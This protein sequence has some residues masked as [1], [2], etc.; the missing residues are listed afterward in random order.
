ME[1]IG[2]ASA[3]PAA[4]EPYAVDAQAI[5]LGGAFIR[6]IMSQARVGVAVLDRDGRFILINEHM[7]ELDGVSSGRHIEQQLIQIA[8][9]FNHDDEAPFLQAL[10]GAYVARDTLRATPSGDRSCMEEWF[11]LAGATGSI[12]G[13]IVNIRDVT[14]RDLAYSRL[15]SVFASAPV[16]IA[17]FDRN[18]RIVSINRHMAEWSALDEA[19]VTGVSA[20]DLARDSWRSM[21]PHFAAALRGEATSVEIDRRAAGAAYGPPHVTA[22]YVP[23]W[24]K[25]VVAGVTITATDISAQVERERAEEAAARF[26]EDVIHMASH[27]LRTPLTSLIAFTERLVRV[28]GS[29]PTMTLDSVQDDL[30]I[31]HGESERMARTLDRILDMVVL[32]SG[33]VQLEREPVALVPI[34]RRQLH[35]LRERY[36]HVVLDERTLGQP[37]V[38]SDGDRIAQ[39]ITNLLENAAR[40][41]GDSAHVVVGVREESDAPFALIEVQDD[42]PGIQEHELD[43]IFERHYRGHTT[44]GATGLGLG[45]YLSRVIATGLGGSLTVSTDQERGVTFALRL[46]LVEE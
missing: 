34:I 28:A 9:F 1:E 42:G 15:Q 39:V 33:S 43:S 7:A 16:G 5:E 29:S 23:V 10:T 12:I 13:V 11:P 41:A 27:E 4:R 45:L 8:P 35:M 40:Y 44:N 6:A 30:V 18:L 17:T 14:E 2:T 25:G 20:Q 38:E 21:E 32:A 31:I 24:F 46:P 36:P 3:A 19:G 37:V 26:Q 22:S